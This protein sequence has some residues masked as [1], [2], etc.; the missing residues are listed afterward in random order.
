MHTK[1]CLYTQFLAVHISTY[2]HLLFHDAIILL[3]HYS[4]ERRELLLTLSGIVGDLAALE[5]RLL[6]NLFDP[7]GR[8]AASSSML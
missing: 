8:W 5:D 1:W 4:R 3:T 7:L 6:P 2:F